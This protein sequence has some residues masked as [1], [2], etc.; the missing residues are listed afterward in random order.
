MH[1]YDGNWKSM[2]ADDNKRGALPTLA[3]SKP[4]YGLHNKGR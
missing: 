3:F 4:C 2:L 1:L